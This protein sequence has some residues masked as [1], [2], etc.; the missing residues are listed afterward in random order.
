[1]QDN[2]NNSLFTEITAEDSA[3]IN[4]AYG[5]CGSY[6]Y[7]SNRQVYTRNYYPRH[8]YMYYPRRERSYRTVVVVRYR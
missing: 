1:M 3:T 4:G 7:R 2:Q 8:N 5:D 6:N